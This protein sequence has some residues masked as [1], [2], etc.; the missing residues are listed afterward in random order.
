VSKGTGHRGDCILFGSHSHFE[1]GGRRGGKG[2]RKKMTN[3][4][5]LDVLLISKLYQLPTAQDVGMMLF[6]SYFCALITIPCWNTLFI[7]QV[8]KL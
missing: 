8:L 5:N 4:P 7:S 1:G 6:W 3:L 2:E